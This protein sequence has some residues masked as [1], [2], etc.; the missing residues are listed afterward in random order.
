M[1]VHV[2]VRLSSQQFMSRQS[3]YTSINCWGRSAPGRSVRFTGRS[4]PPSWSIRFVEFEERKDRGK[5]WQRVSVLLLTVTHFKIDL[6]LQ[7]MVLWSVNNWWIAGEKDNF[8]ITSKLTTR[9]IILKLFI[10]K[11]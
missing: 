7:C 1:K 6:G 2:D 3:C 9:Q 4:A 10:D 5:C 11:N 8:Q